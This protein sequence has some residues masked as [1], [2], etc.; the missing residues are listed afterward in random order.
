MSAIGTVAAEKNQLVDVYNLA[1][2]LVL[3]NADAEAI[4]NLPAGFYIAGGRKILVK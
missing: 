3:R 2:I 4:R 1:G